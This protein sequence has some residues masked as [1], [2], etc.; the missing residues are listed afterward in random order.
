MRRSIII[1]QMIPILRKFDVVKASLF[2]SF[3]RNEET[4]ISDIDLLIEFPKGKS[5]L[6]LV[7]LKLELQ[8]ILHKSVD[9]VT[10]KSVH[11]RLRGLI[12]GDQ[13]KI[14]EKGTG[15]IS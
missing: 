15:N 10:Y 4:E 9:I 12:L 11:P 14:Y 1:P 6:D 13:V 2:G 5:L 8:E 7:G 3:A